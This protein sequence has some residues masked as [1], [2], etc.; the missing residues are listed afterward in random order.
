MTSQNPREELGIKDPFDENFPLFLMQSARAK[1]SNDARQESHDT[2]SP[3]SPL[4]DSLTH[5][6][7]SLLGNS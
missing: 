3:I 2:L 5:T 7:K 6:T 1:T 4:R